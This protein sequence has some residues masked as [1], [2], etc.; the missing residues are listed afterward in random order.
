MI[1]ALGLALGAAGALGSASSKKKN[2]TVEYKPLSPAVDN[3]LTKQAGLLESRQKRTNQ[4]VDQSADFLSQLYG[5]TQQDYEADTNLLRGIRKGGSTYN[6]VMDSIA[7]YGQQLTAANKASTAN[8]VANLK[9]SNFRAGNVGGPNTFELRLLDKLER[10]AELKNAQDMAARKLAADQ[11]LLQMELGTIGAVEELGRGRSN[12]YMAP[13]QMRQ[14]ADS[15]YIDQAR[16]IGDGVSNNLD[17]IVNPPKQSTWERIGPA[18]SQ[19][20]G[21][22]GQYSQM[23]SNQAM[24]DALMKYY[25]NPG[26][27]NQGPI[28]DFNGMP[29]QVG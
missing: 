29:Y 7:E 9:A 21:A 11:S 10:D 27:Y 1:A 20:G 19:I 8:R 3:Y 26:Y 24:Q 2:P 15:Y 14:Q 23:R 18:L 22:L 16:Q 13:E 12:F 4:A 17:R 6:R 5:N 28:G 25:T